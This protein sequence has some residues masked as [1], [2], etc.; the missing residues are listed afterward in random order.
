MNSVI[1][2]GLGVVITGAAGGLGRAFCETLAKAQSRIVVADI[3]LEAAKETAADITQAGGEARAIE[4]DVSNWDSV[5]ALRDE[6]TS[7]LGQVD[8]L[9]NN[10][11]VGVVG[12]VDDTSQ[13]DWEWIMGINL[14]GV[15]YGCRAFLPQMRARNAGYMINVASISGLIAPPNLGPYNVTKAA[16][17]SLSETLY[18]ELVHTGINV[19]VICP[20]FF[21]TGIH[22]SGR[23]KLNPK[24]RDKVQRSMEKSKVQSPEVAALSLEA[25]ISGKLYCL[26][27]SKGTMAWRLKRILPNWFHGKLMARRK[28]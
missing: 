10:A 21:K 25:V 14:W 2:E 12:T 22:D 9:I 19:S 5:A 6:A 27:M 26:P 16:V 28:R 23:G 20:T 17:V 24:L 8:M 11:G 1:P 13:E 15:I 18:S 3:N 4:V 7:Y